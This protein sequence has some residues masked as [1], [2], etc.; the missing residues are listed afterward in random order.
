MLNNPSEFQSLDDLLNST[1]NTIL[2]KGTLINSKRGKNLEIT[3]FAA[4]LL[5]PRVRTSMSLDR[6]LVKSK[7]AEFAWYLSKEKDIDYIKP[8]IAVYGLEEQENNKILGAYGPKIFGS[9][10]GQKSQYERIIE[11]ISKRPMTKQAYLTISEI[12]DY[13]FR[14]DKYSSPPCTIGLHFYV[15]DNKLNLTTYMRSNDAYLGLPHDLFCFTMLQEMISNR[16]GIDL[17]TYTHFAT[18]MHIYEKHL[19]RIKNYLDEGLHEPIE[20]PVITD[21]SSEILDL[22]SKEFDMKTLESSIEKLNNYWTD[23]VLFSSRYLNSN[24]DVN[25]W[26]SKFNNKN[27]QLIALNSIGK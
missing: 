26:K 22:V 18:S 27:M 5:N 3:Q 20:M 17:G 11:Q 10:N 21:C 2:K 6:K 24:F 1:Y 19:E 25:D 9:D 23:Y 4:T 15:R 12:K 8:Y 7:F 16:T 14:D 13:K